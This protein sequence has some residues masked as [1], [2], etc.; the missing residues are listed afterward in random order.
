MIDVAPRPDV[1]RE[2]YLGDGVYARFDGYQIWIRTP[3]E[4]GDHEIALE[5]GV[6]DALVAYEK[7]LRNTVT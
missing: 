2:T 5:P 7:R 6:F 4:G 1:P 3:R